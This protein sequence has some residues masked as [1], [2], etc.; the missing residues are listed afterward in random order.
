MARRL[1]VPGVLIAATALFA[2]ACSTASSA[3][4]SSETT[5][6]SAESSASTAS[7]SASGSSSPSPSATTPTAEPTPDIGD[8]TFKP[9]ADGKKVKALQQR[10]KDLHY[11]PGKVDGEYGPATLVA[12][13]AF[14]KVNGI[15][16][17][18]KIGKKT[19]AAFEDPKLPKVR[20]SDGAADRV[21]VMLKKQILVVYDG[22]EIELISHVSTG[23]GV[24]Y[25]DEYT[26]E[27][28]G[29]VRTSCGD[30]VTPT[31][32]YK[33]SRRI[34]GWRDAPLGMLWNPVYFNGGIAVHG[35]PS[36]PLYPASHGCV[37]IPMHTANLFPDIVDENE[38]VYV[39]K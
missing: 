15:E 21:E 23:S 20:V 13:W 36:V 2:T 25:C 16:P 37:R 3:Q 10:L 14:Q 33:A 26:D 35:A 7:P 38:R 39:R 24:P 22:D 29:E 31:G 4:S 27:A 34:S 12:V 5:P 11:D 1:V 28:T 19:R 17:T 6:A 18:G 9:G 30:A 8:K 32:D